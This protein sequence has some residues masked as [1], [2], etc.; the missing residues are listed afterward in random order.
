MLQKKTT[1]VIKPQKWLMGLLFIVIMQPS[2]LAQSYQLH[3]PRVLIES[4]PGVVYSTP[5]WSPNGQMLAFTA[6]QNKGIFIKNLD[7]GKVFKLTDD[8]N[9]GFGFSWSPDGDF[10]LARPSFFE[11]RRRYSQIKVYPVN[12]GEEIYLQ[13]KARNIQ[14]LPFWAPD[15]SRVGYIQSNELHL[16]K[17]K[18]ISRQKKPASLIRQ[19]HPTP[20]LVY[21]FQNGK[22]SQYNL[23][24]KTHKIIQDT[25]SRHAFNLSVSPSAN[26]LAWQVLGKGM[27][28]WHSAI[29]QHIHIPGGER[30]DWFPDG[31]H[32]VYSINE[33]DGYRITGA[34][35]YVLNALTGQ[36]QKLTNNIAFPAMSPAVSPC[37]TKL[38][39]QNPIDGNIY[40][41]DIEIK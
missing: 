30:A 1:R 38:S 16:D 39:F 14:G 36:T 8:A 10:I 6:N 20:P 15:G 12:Q 11:N 23:T 33:D 37:G 27:F 19:D 3:T 35:L 5:K 17:I 25:E 32:L 9:A 24:A 7:S 26:A 4:D 13:Q 22:I 41:A 28:V 34:E 29:E 21:Y 31:E 40:I 2:V 18:D